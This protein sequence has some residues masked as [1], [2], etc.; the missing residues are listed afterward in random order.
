MV[1][2]LSNESD[3]VGAKSDRALE[4][5]FL[6]CSCSN[7]AIIKLGLFFLDNSNALFNSIGNLASNIDSFFNNYDA[8]GE[9]VFAAAGV[10][11]R[12]LCG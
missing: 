1:F 10:C 7:L 2:D 12:C 6:D 3:A 9:W 8:G 5:S 11:G 4:I